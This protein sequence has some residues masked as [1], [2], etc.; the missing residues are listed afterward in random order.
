MNTLIT[1]ETIT[2]NQTNKEEEKKNEE[3]IKAIVNTSSL[4]ETITLE[5][6]NK[7][8]IKLVT[9]WLNDSSDFEEQTWPLVKEILEE[10]DKK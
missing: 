8:A 2:I 6:K 9:E 4:Q 5:Q 10:R 7:E 1:Q 3:I